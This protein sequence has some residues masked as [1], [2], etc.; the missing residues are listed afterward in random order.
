MTFSNLQLKW[1]ISLVLILL[2]IPASIG[3]LYFVFENAK[4]LE[5]YTALSGLMNFVDTKQQGVI[6]F[7]G[8]NEK[9]AKQL[10]VLVDNAAPHVAQKQFHT[11]SQKV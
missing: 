2:F 1:K 7:L 4:K 8:Q 6:R 10:A 11:N 5:V 3:G 9:L